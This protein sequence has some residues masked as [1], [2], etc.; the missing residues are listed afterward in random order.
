MSKERLEEIKNGTYL[1]YRKHKELREDMDWLIEQAERVQ[2]LEEKLR[3]CNRNYKDEFDKVNFLF[4]KNNKR[5]EI[6]KSYREAISSI[7]QTSKDFREGH[8][9]DIQDSFFVDEIIAII[10]K[11]EVEE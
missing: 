1:Y 2:E 7:K 8:L 10:N 9:L 6:I 5:K 11:L 3:V 4:E